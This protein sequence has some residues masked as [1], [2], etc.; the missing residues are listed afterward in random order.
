MGMIQ[1]EP[2][3]NAFLKLFKKYRVVC[4]VIAL[5]F[6]VPVA[7]FY[8]GSFLDIIIP[9][10][11]KP[12]IKWF[13]KLT[14]FGGSLVAAMITLLILVRDNQKNKAEYKEKIRELVQ[15]EIPFPALEPIAKLSFQD[16][17]GANGT[18]A[19]RSDA[20][21]TYGQYLKVIFE[22][23]SKHTYDASFNISYVDIE[24]NGQTKRYN[25]LSK[26]KHKM[27]SLDGNVSYI[28]FFVFISQD[29]FMLFDRSLRYGFFQLDE[30][31]TLK[32]NICISFFVDIQGVEKHFQ[33]EELLIL[34]NNKQ[35][36]VF[37]CT[38]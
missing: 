13:D 34:S 16:N 9:I 30:Y 35:E 3:E 32:M 29:D 14:S 10:G 4:G 7:L 18:L 24:I 26:I 11:L 36:G 21:N 28:R 17:D 19:L 37:Q 12:S 23:R 6:L 1:I 22:F 38:Y 8:Y 27:H 31:R 25:G 2:N 15:N 20:D 5:Y 33:I